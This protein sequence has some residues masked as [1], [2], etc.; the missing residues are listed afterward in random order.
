MRD[1]ASLLALCIDRGGYLRGARVAEFIAEWEVAVRKHGR[2]IGVEEFARWWKDSY[3]TAYRRLADF[4]AMFP[5]LGPA[6]TPSALMRPL[7]D[8]LEYDEPPYGIALEDVPLDLRAF[9]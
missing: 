8:R 2:D 5:E 6:G 3:R 9:A 4:R 1:R 7:L